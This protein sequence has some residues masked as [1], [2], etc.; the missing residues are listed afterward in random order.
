MYKQQCFEK[1]FDGTN[2]FETDVEFE[3]QVLYN[4]FSNVTFENTV[5]YT[6]DSC[7]NVLGK[8]IVHRE[9]RI[10]DETQF[11]LNSAGD[12]YMLSAGSWILQTN[13]GSNF[14]LSKPFELPQG[15]TGTFVGIRILGETIVYTGDPLIAL[16]DDLF[17]GYQ[18]FLQ[19][20]SV[21]VLGS[22]ANPFDGRVMFNLK[23]TSLST[24]P[25]VLV[26]NCQFSLWTS[27]GL[28][29]AFDTV[30]LNNYSQR[31]NANGLVLRDTINLVSSSLLNLAQG[32]NTPAHRFLSIDGSVNT[33]PSI[34]I[35]Q[36]NFVPA[37]TNETAIYISASLTP[38]ASIT[39]GVYD[40]TNVLV[41]DQ[42]YF[43]MAGLDQTSIYVTSSGNKNVVDSVVECVLRGDGTFVTTTINVQN[44]WVKLNIPTPST[45]VFQQ[46]VSADTTSARMTYTGLEI[47]EVVS[48]AQVNTS[49]QA[50]SHDT[51]IA[52]F[53]MNPSLDCV[54]TNATNLFTKT[55]HGLTNGEYVQ[56]DATVYPTGLTQFVFYVVAN[57]TAN[58]FQ[59]LDVQ[60]GPVVTFTTDGAGVRFLRSILQGLPSGSDT[61]ST[62]FDQIIHS[63]LIT[64]IIPGYIIVLAA[65]NTT[66]SVDIR[67]NRYSSRIRS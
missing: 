59:V 12:K 8:H 26:N 24:P 23:G 49:V 67:C 56:F 10:S 16:F 47:S 6:V 28:L 42:L 57:V 25:V 60:G 17:I 18:L 54:A 53:L 27:V 1:F 7:V 62:R 51:E 30:V 65:R 45:A 31:L 19:I 2:R 36:C 21:V 22:A 3:G 32:F 11:T 44:Q 63:S 35:S 43:D 33:T 15:L 34:Q 9:Y 52:Y 64:G 39:N 55:D 58:T 40:T 29:E 20:T 46:R 66:G 50:G 14:I 5:T 13:D 4:Q 48:F 37:G 61:K 41:S 38:N